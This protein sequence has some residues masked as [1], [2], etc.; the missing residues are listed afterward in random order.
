MT[1]FR[2]DWG[3]SPKSIRKSQVTRAGDKRP[4]RECIHLA[5]CRSKPYSPA[6]GGGRP[7]VA[8][9]DPARARAESPSFPGVRAGPSGRH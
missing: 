9:P 7:K 5:R 4:R 6:R 8:R 1:A 3:P 2:A